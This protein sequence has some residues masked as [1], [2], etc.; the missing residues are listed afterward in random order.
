M[1]PWNRF[2]YRLNHLLVLVRTGDREHARMALADAALLDTEAAGDDDAA[3]LGHRLADGIEAFLL[4]GIE[5]PAGVHHDDVGAG[6]VGRH[7]IALGAQL[8]EDALGI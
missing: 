4:G 7:A 6:V 3:V 2:M 5:K 1:Y 8:G